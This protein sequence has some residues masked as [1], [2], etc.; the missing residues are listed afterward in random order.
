MLREACFLTE[1]FATLYTDKAFPCCEA[2]ILY[3]SMVS[4]HCGSFCAYEGLSSRWR[5]SYIHHIRVFFSPVAS[6]FCISKLSLGSLSPLCMACWHIV[7]W[8]PSL[9]HSVSSQG[10]RFTS[11]VKFSVLISPSE[12]IYHT[13][14]GEKATQK[15]FNRQSA[16]RVNVYFRFNRGL[17]IFI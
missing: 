6:P 5:F 12:T 17:S 2:Q 7:S 3:W 8:C 1:V 4:F 13:I 14:G 11:N 16:R 10:S 9:H 15:W